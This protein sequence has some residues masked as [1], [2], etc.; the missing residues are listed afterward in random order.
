MSSGTSRSRMGRAE[1]KSV[2]SL[3]KGAWN[4]KLTDCRFDTGFA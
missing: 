4:G 2:L 3:W 1:L